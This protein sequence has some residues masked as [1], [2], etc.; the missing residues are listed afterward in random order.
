MNKIQK[1]IQDNNL[2]LTDSGSGLNSTCC[3]IAGYALYA[4]GD[5][6]NYPQLL[7][8]IQEDGLYILDYN[9]SNEL[10]RVY[11]YAY[12]NNYAMWWETLEAQNKYIFETNKE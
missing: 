12:Q 7:N 2:N 5:N 3:A 10:E 9:V 11:D 6:N 1:F 4:N 8:D